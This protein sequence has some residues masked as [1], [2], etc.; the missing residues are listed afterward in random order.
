MMAPAFQ[1]AKQDFLSAHG[2][3]YGYKGWLD[4][5]WWQEVGQ[6]LGPGQHYLD[7]TGAGLYTNSQVTAVMRELTSSTF[8]NPHSRNPSSSRSTQEVE[9]ARQLVLQFFNANPEDYYVVFTKGATESL[10]MVG[11]YFPWAFQAK[12]QPSGTSINADSNTS[13]ITRTISSASSA[14]SM[15]TSSN[16]S[17][18]RGPDTTPSSH[19]IYTQANHKSVLGIGAY[20]KQHG[21]ALHCLTL[22]Q[23]QHWLESSGAPAPPSRTTYRTSNTP[24]TC[25]DAT[26]CGATAAPTQ[27]PTNYHSHGSTSDHMEGCGNVGSDGGVC[28]AQAGGCCPVP[29]AAAEAAAACAPVPVTAVGG[30]GAAGSSCCGA[31]VT[32]HLVAYPAKDN[33][34]GRMYPLQWIQQVHAKSDEAN[35][36][37][38]VLDVA[39]HAASH[40]L[41]LSRVNPDFVTLS[42]YKIFGY[43]SG[44]GA[45]LVRREAAR[46][47]RK[48]YFGG[49]SVDYCTAEDAW[50]VMSGPPAGLEDGTLGFLN[51]AALKHGFNMLQQLGG[52]EAVEHHVEALRSWTYDQLVGLKHSNGSPLLT[53]FGAHAH[54]PQ[55]QGGIF[56]FQVLT[57]SGDRLPGRLVEAAA[58]AAGLH[59]R[60]GCNCNPG[61]CLP[62]LGITPEEERARA[63][64]GHTGPVLVVMRPRPAAHGTN[65]TSTAPQAGTQSDTWAA[66]GTAA[67]AGEGAAVNGA[68]GS[69]PHQLVPV[70]LP[71]GS[72]RASLGALSTFEDCYAFVR[73]LGTTFKDFEVNNMDLLTGVKTVSVLTQ[74]EQEVTVQARIST[75]D[76]GAAL[77]DRSVLKQAG[78]IMMREEEGAVDHHSP[79]A[80]AVAVAEDSDTTVL[81][82]VSSEDSIM[83]EGIKAVVCSQW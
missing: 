51:I 20:A 34:E 54:G 81:S 3:T 44:L 50:A 71:V 17:S 31:G 43:P 74:H 32:H 24:T 65:T 59:L 79:E 53:L 77:Q 55:H 15:S 76:G 46:H 78:N 16:G 37:F 70:P 69:G 21:A 60:T 8:G 28:G 19:F 1:H 80:A 5:N 72:V 27:D 67:A 29:P 36:Y 68:E 48:V 45:L 23:M 52:I 39:A 26:C 58:T 66:S 33:Y 7:M 22:D 64:E 10:K 47:L 14:S 13:S 25:T 42:F 40:A 56:Q 49:G 57:S 6:R 18:I 82:A 30:P 9:A 62:N 2:D 83:A 73:F 75:S 41:D 63:A 11:E 61:R 12:P 38:V 35:R 4:Q